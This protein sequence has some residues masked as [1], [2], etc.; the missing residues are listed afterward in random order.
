MIY[1]DKGTE[2]ELPAIFFTNYCILLAARSYKQMQEFV[3]QIFIM[4]GSSERLWQVQGA[5]DWRILPVITE[6]VSR[7]GKNLMYDEN[8]CGKREHACDGG[9]TETGCLWRGLK[10]SRLLKEGGHIWNWSYIA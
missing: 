10:S 8:V 6:A 3:C 4:K 1:K 2:A 9:G 7:K 5:A